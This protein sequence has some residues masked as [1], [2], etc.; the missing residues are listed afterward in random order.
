MDLYYL[1]T[2]FQYF[3]KYK[4]LI[5][6]ILCATATT[7]WSQV[8]SDISLKNTSDLILLTSNVTGNEHNNSATK[9]TDVSLQVQ[10]FCSDSLN[11]VRISWAGPAGF[12]SFD[13]YRNEVLIASNIKTAYY[14]DSAVSPAAY[15]HYSIT[16]KNEKEIF[17][18]PISPDV[19]TSPCFSTLS[20]VNPFQITVSPNPSP[21]VFYFTAS[22]LRNKIL[23]IEVLNTTGTRVYHQQTKSMAADF[24]QTIDLNNAAPGIYYMKVQIDRNTYFKQLVKQ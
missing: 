11:L 16:A 14:V 2:P 17:S 24:I 19:F 5:L 4:L 1:Q 8:S 12:K 20:K 7:G 15:Y 3:M 6:F 23:N 21:S 22:N 13:V 18:S 10:A 9:P